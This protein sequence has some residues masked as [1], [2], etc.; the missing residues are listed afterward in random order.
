MVLRI[1]HSHLSALTDS[2]SG[3]FSTFP[4]EYLT[5]S[6]VIVCHRSGLLGRAA[7]QVTSWL[8][9]SSGWL[10][11]SQVPIVVEP[12]LVGVQDVG[13]QSLR[14]LCGEGAQRAMSR[15]IAIFHFY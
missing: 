12:T 5:S 6:P 3:W 13:R 14:E 2:V 7:C 15:I 9:A 1:Q 8:V 11:S 4:A 10:T